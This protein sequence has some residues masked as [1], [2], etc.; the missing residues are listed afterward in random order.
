MTS[1]FD[2]ATGEVIAEVLADSAPG[3]QVGAQTQG[4]IDDPHDGRVDSWVGTKQEDGS[5]S[6]SKSHTY[7][8]DRDD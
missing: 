3:E 1:D 2:N 6:I 7:G 8:D 4:H 5:V